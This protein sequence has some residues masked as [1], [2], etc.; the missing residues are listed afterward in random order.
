MLQRTAP[1]S[2]GADHNDRNQSCVSNPAS[3]KLAKS[4]SVNKPADVTTNARG[5]PS[6]L[7]RLAFVLVGIGSFQDFTERQHE[8]LGIEPQRPVVDVH[9]IQRNAAPELCGGSR[10]ATRTVDL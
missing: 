5:N 9:E 8:D 7:M 6:P 10:G 2:V 3:N 1:E 4:S